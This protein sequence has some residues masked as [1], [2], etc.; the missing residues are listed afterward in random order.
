MMDLIS[1]IDKEK[2]CDINNEL[3]NDFSVLI[4][5]DTYCVPYNLLDKYNILETYDDILIED[6]K[7]KINDFL[8]SLFKCNSIYTNQF[9]EM[10]RLIGQY[11]IYCIL[12]INK[13]HKNE[14]SK[15]ISELE[16]KDNIIIKL[17]EQLEFINIDFQKL[18]N[19]LDEQVIINDEKQIEIDSLESAF[20]RI[21]HNNKRHST[22]ENTKNDEYNKCIT[23]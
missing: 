19:S 22:Y 4:F 14:C 12:E 8:K 23:M 5:N 20:N 9:L 13:D 18:K 11:Y 2:K 17:E 10:Q 1:Y 7:I 16:N 3:I 21:K 15:Y 6:E